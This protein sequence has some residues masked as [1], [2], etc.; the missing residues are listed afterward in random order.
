MGG[1]WKNRNKTTLSIV[2]R[3][4]FEEMPSG[5]YFSGYDF[6]NLCVKKCPKFRKRYPDT[7]LHQMRAFFRGEY[8]CICHKKSL[9]QKL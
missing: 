6:R 1:S 4:A 3:E 8:I 9:Y 7:F 2:I 5:T